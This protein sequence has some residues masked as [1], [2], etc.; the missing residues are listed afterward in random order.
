[1]SDRRG[2]LWVH[3]FK[4]DR[5]NAGIFMNVLAE[6]LENEDFP[7][8]LHYI[9]NMRSPLAIVQSLIH[10]RTVAAKYSI[11]HAQFG[12]ACGLLSSAVKSRK[13][14]S[15]RGSDFYRLMEG[16]LL[17]RAHGFLAQSMTLLS[18][19]RYDHIIVMSDRMRNLLAKYVDPK[20]VSVIPD[21]ID[22]ERFRP[23]P[24]MAAR[25]ALGC[26]EDF[27]PWVLFPTIHET[28]PIKR[29]WLARQA[30]EEARRLV[31]N[32]KLKVASG[33]AHDTMP[34]MINASSVVLMTSAH[35][36]WPNSVKE[37]LACN[38]PFVA[39][40]VSDLS[41]IASAE[42]SC[43]VEDPD[44][45][46]LGKA[47]VRAVQAPRAQLRDHVLSMGHAIVARRLIDL[48]RTLS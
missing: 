20:K 13:I 37:G 8:D 48:Y 42:S 10:L 33:I 15:L 26:G 9:G 18:I 17:Y 6:A 22:L 38:V 35:E 3:N 7:V 34:L 31:P 39:T 41:T 32:L 5:Q 23:M 47:I 40:D 16:P 14:L 11:V 30:F 25:E 44:P 43:S 29:P 21:G 46:S 36:G 4:P 45:A 24:Q 2:V 1:M 19:G 28:N 12:S 27:A